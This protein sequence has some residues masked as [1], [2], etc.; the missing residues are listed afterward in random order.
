MIGLMTL[1]FLGILMFVVLAGLFAV[2]VLVKSVIWLVTLPFRLLFGVLFLPLML[3]K[4]VVGGLLFV[5]LAPIVVVAVAGAV[6]AA[7][8]ALAVP[9]FPLLCIAFVVWVVMRSNRPAVA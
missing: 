7:L 6:I 1:A 3:L 8:A 9:L 5:V 2:M 4:L